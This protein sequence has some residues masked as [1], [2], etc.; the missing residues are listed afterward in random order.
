MQDKLKQLNEE[1]LPQ[2]FQMLEEEK[3]VSEVRIEHGARVDLKLKNVFLNRI[4]FYVKKE[5]RE[6]YD[7]LKNILVLSFS[8]FFA[9]MVYLRVL[10]YYN[11]PEIFSSFYIILN[12]LLALFFVNVIWKMAQWEGSYL[13]SV[14]VLMFIFSLGDLLE[15]KENINNIAFVVRFVLQLISGSLALYLYRNIFPTHGIMGA[16]K[17]DIK[18]RNILDDFR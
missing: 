2:A 16:P 18:E 14:I 3:S 11:N 9:I 10:D 13:R 8:L 6:K 15:I 4:S 1:I 5:L 12:V 17:E 7:L